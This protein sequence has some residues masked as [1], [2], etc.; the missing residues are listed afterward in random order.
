M[1]THENTEW[2]EEL[3]IILQLWILILL[4]HTRILQQVLLLG[5]IEFP[6]CIVPS[7]FLKLMYI[8]AIFFSTNMDIY[9]VSWDRLFL[10]GLV[11]WH[12]ERHCRCTIKKNFAFCRCNCY[13]NTKGSDSIHR[14]IWYNEFKYFKH[15]WSIRIPALGNTPI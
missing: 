7:D 3:M 10:Q 15:G 1:Y 8:L 5:L 12:S 14:W 9:T 6:E 4:I 11:K 2:I 13:D